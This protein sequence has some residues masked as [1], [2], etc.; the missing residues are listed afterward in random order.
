MILKT[1]NFE[2]WAI[3]YL[4]PVFL[5]KFCYHYCASKDAKALMKVFQHP[6]F[7]N[8]NKAGPYLLHI[9]IETQYTVHTC[10]GC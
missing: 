2:D 6:Q 9:I 5:I 7:Q 3:K 1:H 10:Q 8:S 4:S